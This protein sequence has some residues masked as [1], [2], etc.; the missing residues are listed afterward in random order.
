MNINQKVYVEIINVIRLTIVSP[1]DGQ[2]QRVS[3][4]IIK[5]M[6]E[7]FMIS[8]VILYKETMW[9]HD[10]SPC[11]QAAE[12]FISDSMGKLS[13]TTSGESALSSADLVVEA[14]TENLPLK[15][16]RVAALFFFKW[17]DNIKKSIFR[18]NF[19]L[20]SYSY[21]LQVWFKDLWLNLHLLPFIYLSGHCLF[22]PFWII[23]TMVNIYI[24]V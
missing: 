12:A 24:Y 23:Y 14:I 6:T 20:F 7:L 10:R 4:C 11:R 13:L 9:K 22:P 1:E 16:V 17:G 3:N 19:I 18:N 21:I 2:T 15:Q 5:Y 8:L